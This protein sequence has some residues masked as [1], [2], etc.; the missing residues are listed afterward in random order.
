MSEIDR[1]PDE[2]ILQHLGSVVLLC[3]N[4]LPSAAQSTILNQANDI[5]GIVP[6][7]GIRNEIE[8]LLLR[9]GKA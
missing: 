7:P 5:I 1:P 4:E 6:V 3:W 2:L 8:G 9:Y